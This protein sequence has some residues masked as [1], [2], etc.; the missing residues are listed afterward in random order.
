MLGR[1]V[2]ETENEV[3]LK[4]TRA[5]VYDRNKEDDTKNDKEIREGNAR[6]KGKARREVKKGDC[7]GMEKG[8]GK[9]R[10]GEWKRK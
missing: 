4:A 6:R 9:G 5:K 3:T 1:L 2:R 7:Y 8:R 10:E